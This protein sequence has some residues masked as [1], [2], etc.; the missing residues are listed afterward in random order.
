[1]AE[2]VAEL[3]YQGEIQVQP[4]RRGTFLGRDHLQELIERALGDRYSFGAGWRGHAVVTIE[5]YDEEPDAP[6]G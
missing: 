3:R 2:P 6:A 5:L 1:M 4:Y